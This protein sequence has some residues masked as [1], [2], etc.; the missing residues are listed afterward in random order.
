MSRRDFS[1]RTTVLS[2]SL[3]LCRHAFAIAI[4]VATSTA[5]AATPAI[6]EPA[7]TAPTI[8]QPSAPDGAALFATHCASCHGALGAGDGELAPS[9]SVVLQDLR[10]LTA[11]SDGVFPRDFVVKIID[12]RTRRAAHGPEDMPVWGGVF[13]REA[14]ENSQDPDTVDARID[15]LANYL[16]AI[17]RTDPPVH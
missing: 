12:G 11:R 6:M 10:Y 9:L 15:A 13:S 14:A 3:L 16:Q 5:Y 17:Q 8:E 1:T 7:V 4:V 2:G